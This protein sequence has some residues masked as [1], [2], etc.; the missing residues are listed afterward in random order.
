MSI[1]AISDKKQIAP[2]FDGWQETMIWSCLQD[3]MGLAFTNHPT[4]PTAG[5]IQI[6]DFCFF[7]GEPDEELVA[8]LPEGA[9]TEFLIMV[10]RH[11]GWSKVIEQ[12]WGKQA[13]KRERYS[14]R[15]DPAVFHKDQLYHYIS[16]LPEHYE[17]LSIDEFWYQQISKS[18]WAG[19]LCSQFL[20]YQDYE[21]RGIGV[22]AVRQGELVSG[23]SSYTV[24]REGIEIEI[25]TKKSER[26]KG[27]ALACAGKLILECLERG[28]YPSWDAQNKGSLAL[29]EKLGYQF[30][31]AYPVYEIIRRE[32]DGTND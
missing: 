8:H 20:D 2:L 14:T 30:D 32:S 31:E 23:A 19:D 16:M 18:D 12:V 11:E 21:T 24:Y 22:V 6:A 26:R 13:T 7:A 27:L 1:Y 3:C 17:I 28:L 29:A 25:D 10:P 9:N 15:K 4:E 5:K